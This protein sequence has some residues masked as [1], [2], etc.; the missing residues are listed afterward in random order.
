VQAERWRR[1]NELF[2]AALERPA[3]ARRAFLDASCAGDAELREEVESLLAAHLEAE[4]FIEAPAYEVGAELLHGAPPQRSDADPG[5]LAGKQLGFYRIERRIG[6]G[7]MG[8]VY[9]AED[10]RL[11]RR[12][13]IKALAEHLGR[14]DRSRERLRR[15]ARAAAALSHPGIAT[16]FA[17]EEFD[18]H[19]YVVYEYAEG[20][21]LREELDDGPLPLADAVATGLAIARALE[22]AHRQ[23]IVHRDLKPENVVRILDGSIKVLDFGLA[24]FQASPLSG[25]VAAEDDAA[26]TAARLTLPGMLLG[27]PAYMAP[28]QLR[29][30][31]V[32]FRA[33]I[34][35][36]GIVLY[37]LAS[38]A[39]P[40]EGGD[41]ASTIARILEVEPRDLE[42][43][44]GIDDPGLVAIFETC[45][46]KNPAS[47][48]AS[49]GELVEDL[50]ALAAALA[51]QGTVAPPTSGRHAGERMRARGRHDAERTAPNG[52]DGERPSGP[53]RDR[54]GDDL[55]EGSG[56]DR[57]GDGVVAGS[58]SDRRGDDVVAASGSVRRGDDVGTEAAAAPRHDAFWWWRFHQVA[59]GICY[60]PLLYALWWAKEIG[61]SGWVAMASAVVFFV[62]VLPIT[63]AS[64][65]RLHLTFTARYYPEQLDHQRRGSAPWIHLS[66]RL[67]ALLVAIAALLVGPSSLLLAVILAGAAAGILVF[68]IMIEPTTT[69][70]AFPADETPADRNRRS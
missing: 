33:D 23:G 31:D 29:G 61:A 41:P 67:F 42:A 27:T 34:F 4:G 24:S 40:F 35:S 45:L 13:A 12:V 20:Q 25:S 14:D 51:G 55:V 53:A 54:R 17:L 68:A 30:R 60:W 65:L 36:F 39:H 11:G 16:V 50:A 59:L 37:E 26:E 64:S 5:S 46:Q 56:S 19:L 47:R 6:T 62:G 21:T 32:D 18:G 15:E 2:H 63:V 22:A 58:G 66:E 1:I 8:V 57:R 44:G 48:Y 38:G 7:G 49:T 28:E 52:R 10:T 69:R 3:G 9:L 43:A 70:A